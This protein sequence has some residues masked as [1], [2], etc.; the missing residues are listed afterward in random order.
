MGF[1]ELVIG[2]DVL[3]KLNIQFRILICKNNKFI[4]FSDKPEMLYTEQSFLEG[5]FNASTNITTKYV[6]MN[7]IVNLTCEADAN[8]LPNFMW[9]N[10][11]KTIPAELITNEDTLSTLT[12]SF[13]C[14]FRKILKFITFVFTN[15]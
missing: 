13:G 9:L 11:G 15:V 4:A 3:C 7:S 8:P 12:V 10:R 14:T 2:L 6:L 5:I 1:K